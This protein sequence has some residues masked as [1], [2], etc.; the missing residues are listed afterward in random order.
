[1]CKMKVYYNS[2]AAIVVNGDWWSANLFCSLKE[3]C[4]NRDAVKVKAFNL[5]YVQLL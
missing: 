1:M 5:C 3:K 2:V 4:S